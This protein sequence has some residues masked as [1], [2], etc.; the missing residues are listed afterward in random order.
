MELHFRQIYGM[1]ETS[2]AVVINCPKSYQRDLPK[3]EYYKLRSRQG[4]FFPGL[5]MKVIGQDGEIKWD[6]EEMGELCLSGP[7]IAGS[8]YNDERTA[9]SMKDGW[10]YTGDIVTVDPEGLLKLLIVRKI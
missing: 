3:E 6:G 1:T 10:L 4:Y 9:D 7:W 8:Y 2:P 5:E